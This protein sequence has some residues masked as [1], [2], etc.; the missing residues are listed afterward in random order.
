MSFSRT[1]SREWKSPTGIRASVISTYAIPISRENSE[2]PSQAS[3]VRAGNRVTLGVKSLQTTIE[4]LPQTETAESVQAVSGGVE[5]KWNSRAYPM[6]M[7]RDAVTGEV[8]SFS[9]GGTARFQSKGARP[10]DL[11]FPTAFTAG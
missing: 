2:R 7:T 10:V 6:V 11:I 3:V 8:I 9:R 1:S 4:A 5:L